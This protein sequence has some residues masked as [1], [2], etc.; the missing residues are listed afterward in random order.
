MKMFLY[1]KN[2][3]FKNKKELLNIQSYLGVLIN[4][5]P[6]EEIKAKVGAEQWTEIKSILTKSKTK[7]HITNCHLSLTGFSEEDY[8]EVIMKMNPLPNFI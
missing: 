5:M 4:Q 3:H 7:K 8:S 1:L 6:R 2:M